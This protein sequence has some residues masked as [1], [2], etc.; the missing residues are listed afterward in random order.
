MRKPS[1]HGPVNI[2]ASFNRFLLFAAYSMAAHAQNTAELS[3]TQAIT[4]LAALQLLDGPL[5][6]LLSSIPTGWAALSCFERVQEFLMEPGHP[7]RRSEATPD[8]TVQCLEPQHG[9]EMRS[10]PETD[11]TVTICVE[12]ATFGWPDSY[13]IHLGDVSFSSKALL[14]AVVG[15]VGCGKSTLLRALIGEANVLQGSVHVS[16][17]EIAYGGQSP[18]IF[19]G[20][21]RDNVLA[22]SPLDEPWYIAVV[23]ACALDLDIQNMPEGDS[24]RVGSKG[25]EL[26]GGQ[27][28]RLVCPASSHVHPKD[29]GTQLTRSEIVYCAGAVLEKEAGYLGRRPQWHGL[30][31]REHG[32]P[33]CL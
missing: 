14:V 15:P 19:E 18:W 11:T 6:E 32:L 29:T 3:V 1:N 4:A 25:M 31:H 20:S 26:S 17:S 33:A 22:G 30:H 28:Q 8:P 12:K 5:S 23:H 16:I 7:E 13:V 9:I 21:I 10:I 2:P 27:K 24:A